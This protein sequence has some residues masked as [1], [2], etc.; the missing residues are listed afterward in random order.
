MIRTRTGGKEGRKKKDKEER[1]KIKRGDR[2]ISADD[3]EGKIARGD[4]GGGHGRPGGI[5]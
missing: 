2:I 1:G 3:G 4:H 5:G